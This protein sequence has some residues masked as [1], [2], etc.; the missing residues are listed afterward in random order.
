M[1]RSDK[2]IDY[3]DTET[4]KKFLDQHGRLLPR[5]I[6]GVSAKNQRTI[7]QAVKNARFMG[8]LPYLSK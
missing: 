7:A 5:R 8:L 4:L 3:K 2:H 1:I 6:T